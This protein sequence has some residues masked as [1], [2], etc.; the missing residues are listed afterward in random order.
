MFSLPD[1]PR[2]LKLLGMKTMDVG[3][4][5]VEIGLLDQLQIGALGVEIG[6]DSLAVDLLAIGKRLRRSPCRHAR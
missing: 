2:I 6:D 4:D 1:E 5:R 3:I